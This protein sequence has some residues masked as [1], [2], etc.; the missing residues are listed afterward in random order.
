MFRDG[1]THLAEG[2]HEKVRILF[3]DGKDASCIVQCLRKSHQCSLMHIKL[4]TG[5]THPIR[6]QLAAEGYPLIG[7]VKYGAQPGQ[8][9]HLHALR[10]VL[11]CTEELKGINLSGISINVLPTWTN[12]LAVHEFP[13]L[14]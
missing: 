10:I 11:P 3:Q 13:D 12:W 9:L 8:A 2:N 7:D 14:L 4:L 5:R 6:V 1:M